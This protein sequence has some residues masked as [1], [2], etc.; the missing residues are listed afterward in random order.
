MNLTFEKGVQGRIYCM[1]SISV[2]QVLLWS[3]VN[4]TTYFFIS[5]INWQYQLES[6][7]TYTKTASL[8]VY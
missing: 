3:K 8:T 5:R 1:K 6:I 7:R 4:V 2:R